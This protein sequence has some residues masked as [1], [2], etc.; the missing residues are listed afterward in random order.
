MTAPSKQQP[1]SK[2]VGAVTTLPPVARPSGGALQPITLTEPSAPTPL[3]VA[4]FAVQQQQQRAIRRLEHRHPA[5]GGAPR[6]LE[7]RPS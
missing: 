6:K 2:A 4:D 3:E 5:E 1:P 7:R